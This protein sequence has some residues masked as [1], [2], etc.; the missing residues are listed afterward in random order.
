[1]E[2]IDIVLFHISLNGVGDR[3]GVIENVTTKCLLLGILNLL[4]FWQKKKH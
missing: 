4:H 2:E 1:M 3:I